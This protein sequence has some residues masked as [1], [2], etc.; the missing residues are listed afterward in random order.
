MYTSTS[1][2]AALLR[3]RFPHAFKHP[4][5]L[6]VGILADL[7]EALPQVPAA[8]LAKVLAHHCRRIAYQAG[9][10]AGSE[11]V[12]L[13]GRPAGTVE[14]GHQQ[15]AAARVAAHEALKA[16]KPGGKPAK[17]ATGGNKPAGQ[18]AAAT[19]T[20]ARVPAATPV[21]VVKKRRKLET[22]PK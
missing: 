18:R 5:P 16:R 1:R 4:R 19:P 7:V 17:R 6:K 11:R 15:A 12:D 22:P 10:A 20:P 14:P 13:S 2:T 9:V 3:E 8:M 21:V